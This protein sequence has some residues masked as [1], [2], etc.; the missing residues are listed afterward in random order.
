MNMLML[1]SE[2]STKF[3]NF[4]IYDSHIIGIKNGLVY[5]IIL[6]IIMVILS[7]VF[8]YRLQKTSDEEDTN[9]SVSFFSI[10]IVAIISALITFGGAMLINNI[11]CDK[12]DK[13]YQE[14][15]TKI[16]ESNKTYDVI[17][18]TMK[19]DSPKKVYICSIIDENNSIKD[20]DIPYE[21]MQLTNDT[22]AYATLQYNDIRYPN[23]NTNTVIESANIHVTPDMLE[24]IKQKSRNNNG[25]TKSIFLFPITYPVY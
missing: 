22:S 5:T 14:S 19:P 9:D 10:S 18:L 7:A 15:A 6:M 23:G 1:L 16:S 4:I 12:Y 25:N 11:I 20:I 24:D 8:V 3:D 2:I 17:S 21:N 13:L